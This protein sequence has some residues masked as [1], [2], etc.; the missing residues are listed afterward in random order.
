LFSL[1]L[2]GSSHLEDFRVLLLEVG[3]V[4]E[5]VRGRGVREVE[6]F[7]AEAAVAPP[8]EPE[9]GDGL[10]LKTESKWLNLDSSSTDSSSTDS[11]S[12][13]SSS[14]DSLSTNSLSTDSLSTDSL[15]THISSTSF[16]YVMLAKRTFR[17]VGNVPVLIVQ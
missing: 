8:A 4:E 12:T 14:T 9:S 11:S 13:D 17:F 15:S 1:E 7:A 6:A 2:G 5:L 3:A 10:A 16:I